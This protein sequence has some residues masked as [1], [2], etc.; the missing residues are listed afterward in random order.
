MEVGCTERSLRTA[1]T[2]GNEGC[3]EKTSQELEGGVGRM[4]IHL[5]T[6]HILE[7]PGAHRMGRFLLRRFWFLWLHQEGVGSRKQ[8]EGEPAR[9]FTPL[10][11]GEI[12][13]Q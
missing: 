4:L 6:S 3:R 8:V 10:Q 7:D 1:E 9:L 5:A 13:Q 2:R 12:E 11:A